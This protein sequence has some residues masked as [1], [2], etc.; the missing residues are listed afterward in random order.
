MSST[1]LPEFEIENLKIEEP[2]RNDAKTG[3][4]IVYTIR[5]CSFGMVNLL[6]L[7]LIFFFASIYKYLFVAF[8]PSIGIDGSNQLEFETDGPGC[9]EP[10][11]EEHTK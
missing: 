6:F 9:P 11:I 1:P 5:N 3:D 7:L 10:I 8:N 2:Q 4:K